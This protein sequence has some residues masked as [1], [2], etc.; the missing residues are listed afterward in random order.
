M[1]RALCAALV[2]LALL[3]PAWARGAAVEQELGGHLKAR[4]GTSFPRDDTLSQSVGLSPNTDASVEARLKHRAFLGSR[5][6][7]EM[8]YEVIAGHSESRRDAQRIADRYFMLP[9]VTLAPPVDDS[10][11]FLDLSHVATDDD[12]DVVT[13]RIDRLYAAYTPPWGEVRVGRQAV[14]WGHGFLFN[15]MDLISPFAP[16]DIERDYKTGEDMVFVRVPAGRADVQVMYV[17][18]RDAATRDVDFEQASVGGKVGMAFGSTEVELLAARHYRDTVAG[19]GLVGY[20]GDAAW[21]V[22]GTWTALHT[23]SRGRSGYASVTAN[24]DRSWVAGGRNWYGYVELHANG[25]SRNDFTDQYTDPAV[26]R[27]IARGEMYT[28]GTAYAGAHVDC[29]VHPLVHAFATGMVNLDDGSGTALPGVSI[30]LADNM[31]LTV[32]ASLPFGDAG[33]EFGGYPLPGTPPG[34]DVDVKPARR[35]SAWV[36]WYF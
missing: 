26:A 25:L 24:V 4:V 36:G 5:V 11:S 14:T 8:H 6:H 35:V 31:D 3:A 10:T 2:C 29:E 27:R 12:G 20:A 32:H 30:D 23:A 21:R 1:R 18:R 16:T 33:T 28:L 13:H 7:T 9:G 15:P 19:L 17:P 34:M 22:D